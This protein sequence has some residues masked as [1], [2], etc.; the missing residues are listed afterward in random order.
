[1]NNDNNQ[2]DQG[3]IVNRSTPG[4][5][6]PFMD[7]TPSVAS[8]GSRPVI[9]P[10]PT[11]GDPMLATSGFDQA[12]A[13]SGSAPTPTLT[14]TPMPSPDEF[15]EAGL[16]SDPAAQ[17]SVSVPGAGSD[18]NSTQQSAPQSASDINLS[19]TPQ[20]VSN[21][22]ASTSSEDSYQSS[23]N[24]SV[25]PHLTNNNNF[26]KPA[27]EDIA[28]PSVSRFRPGNKNQQ[29]P[30]SNDVS[31]P[32][33]PHDI[34]GQSAM[35]GEFKR[36]KGKKILFIILA[37]V[38]L[39]G[40]AFGG[41]M[42]FAKKNDSNSSQNTNADN[43]ATTNDT[44]QQDQPNADSKLFTSKFSLFSVENAEGWEVEDKDITAEFQG[45]A[46]VNNTTYGSVTFKIND[47]QNFV[48]KRRPSGRGG[49]C[50]P[51]ANDVLF[52][53]GN[54]CDSEEML[55]VEK[56]S[57]DKFSSQNEPSAHNYYLTRIKYMDAKHDKPTTITGITSV[58][59][60]TQ[61]EVG[62]SY[63]GAAYGDTAISLNGDT[64]LFSISDNEGNL[65]QLSEDDLA[66][67]ET[68]L[69]TFRLI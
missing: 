29:T 22:S 67:V 11:L 57:D 50:D 58:L 47:D 33:A 26:K 13:T 40:A 41:Y 25:L 24:P 59:P 45:A 37:I 63:M 8:P 14:P 27:S 69:R 35:Y 4:A 9:P 39:A 17:D 52:K 30:A 42:L 38:V 28:K 51:G 3:G 6:R 46:D 31:A 60:S 65:T 54:Q 66:K 49:Y 55:L 12:S 10:P 64:I 48:I 21:D 19:E 32:S 7:V 20:P 61:L 43:S 68:M 15:D 44:T 62:D 18:N 34:H 53:I 2:N 56:L 16:G 1:M 5:G 36:P 23:A